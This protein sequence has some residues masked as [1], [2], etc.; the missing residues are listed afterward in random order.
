MC[1]VV[2]GAAD[3]G[4]VRSVLMTCVR[5]SGSAGTPSADAAGRRPPSGSPFWSCS[6]TSIS[7]RRPSTRGGSAGRP[8]ETPGRRN[9]TTCPIVPGHRP[10]HRA[11]RASP[12]AVSR[13]GEIGRPSGWTWRPRP[14]WQPHEKPV[15]CHGPRS[16]VW[17]GGRS[18]A[19][20]GTLG[21]AGTAGDRAAGGWHHRR[22]GRTSA[23]AGSG[24]R[25]ARAQPRG[26][27]RAGRRG[28]DAHRAARRPRRTSRSR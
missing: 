14:P 10:A 2:A 7:C 15:S 11:S 13:S 3:T 25:R 12:P 26:G 17:S 21:V 22:R 4:A 1:T 20:V 24:G 19:T 6:D 8:G 9:R 16:S 27:V 28:R 5:P 18:G 23:A